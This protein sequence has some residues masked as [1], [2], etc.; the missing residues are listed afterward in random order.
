MRLVRRRIPSADS[1]LS[2]KRRASRFLHLHGALLER[3]STMP[4]KSLSFASFTLTALTALTACSSSDHDRADGSS[5]EKTDTTDEVAAAF[6]VHDT[7]IVG[8][9]DY[10]QT[11]AL[12]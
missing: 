9:L 1:R 8:S 7:K 3:A 10:G 11:S 12:T 4:S 2:Q 5:G 6:S